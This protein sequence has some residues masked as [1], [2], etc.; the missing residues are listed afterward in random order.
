MTP[1]ERLQRCQELLQLLAFLKCYAKKRTTSRDSVFDLSLKC[2]E[3]KELPLLV[4]TLRN[5]DVFADYFRDFVN[6]SSFLVEE[7]YG[8]SPSFEEGLIS[9]DE[10]M[11]F[12]F[13][14]CFCIL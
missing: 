11:R 13:F 3:G 6:F 5:M 1:E 7:E 8:V 10:G 2:A 14:L 9:S 4:R 12:F